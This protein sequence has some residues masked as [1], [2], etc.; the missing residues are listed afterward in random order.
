MMI[1]DNSYTLLNLK[2]D[3]LPLPEPITREELEKILKTAKTIEL[4]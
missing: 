3:T 4:D 1:M 2:T